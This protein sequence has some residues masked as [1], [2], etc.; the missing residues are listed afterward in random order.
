MDVAPKAPADAGI[1]YDGRISHSTGPATPRVP[2][3]ARGILVPSGHDGSPSAS[4]RDQPAGS[5]R[6]ASSAARHPRPVRLPNSPARHAHD[7]ANV[8]TDGMESVVERVDPE[9][10]H[11]VVVGFDLWCR[12][13]R[14]YDYFRP[15]ELGSARS[16]VD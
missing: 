6:Y 2:L 1:L 15:G 4:P 16:T 5:P 12:G 14:W 7:Q 13:T 8:P 11:P 3:H 10:D 9:R